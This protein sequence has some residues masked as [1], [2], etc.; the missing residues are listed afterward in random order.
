[1]GGVLP[2]TK[3]ASVGNLPGSHRV[4]RSGGMGKTDEQGS[5]SKH[6]APHAA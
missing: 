3:K 5:P 4:I 1:M 6:A 2:T